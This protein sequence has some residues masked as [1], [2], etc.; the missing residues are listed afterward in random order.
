MKN[1]PPDPRIKLLAERMAEQIIAEWKFREELMRIAEEL[2]VEPPI[3]V[4]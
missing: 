3:D 4:V 1:D 2:K